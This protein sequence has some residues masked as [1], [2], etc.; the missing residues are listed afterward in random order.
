MEGAEKKGNKSRLA[1]TWKKVGEEEEEKNEAG[2][3]WEKKKR[4]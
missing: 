1:A 4:E 2:K 3:R